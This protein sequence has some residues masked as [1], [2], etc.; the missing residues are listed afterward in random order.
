MSEQPRIYLIS[1]PEIDLIEF[2]QTLQR[3]LGDFDIACLRLALTGSNEAQ[4][5][6]SCDACRDIAIAHDVAI[7]VDNHVHLAERLGL[8]GVHLTD[9]SKSVREARKLLGPDA[10][11]GAYC[12]QSRHDGMNA[13]EAGADY[14][15]F[16]PVG[17]HSLND[18]QTAPLELFQWW[19]EMIE[20]PVVA[21]GHL[22]QDSIAKLAPHTDFFGVS[23]IWA[24][25][26]PCTTLKELIT[27]IA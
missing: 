12:A 20:V 9:A 17:A 8:D 14:V 22:S 18:G 10:I 4:I 25:Q 11:V 16:G 15:S 26:D 27:P 23:E 3:V 1:P 19:S 24:A 21:E 6:K 5:A 7:V 13:G 2:P